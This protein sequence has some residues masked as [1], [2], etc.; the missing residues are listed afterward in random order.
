MRDIPSSGCGS[1]GEIGLSDRSVSQAKETSV[2]V[3]KQFAEMVKEL[4]K[5]QTEAKHEIQRV[6]E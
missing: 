3:G 6:P 5:Q 1:Y 2:E 4:C